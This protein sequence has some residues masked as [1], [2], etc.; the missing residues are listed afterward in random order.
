M[1]V[2]QNRLQLLGGI[3][4]ELF[5]GQ[6]V[7]LFFESARSCPSSSDIRPKSAVSTRTPFFSIDASV[8]KSGVSTSR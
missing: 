4:V 5:S 1:L 6:T 2:E 7:N 3:D 8:N